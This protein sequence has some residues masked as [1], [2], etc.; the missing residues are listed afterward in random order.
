M[1]EP[2]QHDAKTEHLVPPPKRA[3]A[4]T[5]IPV[6][7]SQLGI[8]LAFIVIVAI[9]SILKPQVFLSMEN[10]TNIVK[11]T[12]VASVVG[13]GMTIV[14]LAGGI[15][16]SVGSII[17]MCG[18]VAALLLAQGIPIPIAILAALLLGTLFGFING[19]VSVRWK[20]Q[21]FLVTLGS[22]SVARGLAL[23]FSGG[24][25]VYIDNK[26]FLNI[27]GRGNIGPVPVLLIWTLVFLVI[28][29]ALI[30]RSTYG[31]RVRAV[32]GNETAARQSGVRVGRVKTIAFMLSGFFAAFAALMMAGR[33][34]SGLPSVGVGMELDAITAAVLG[35]T[36]FAGEGGSM[37]GTLF[38]ALVLG[39][40]TA[41]LTILGVDPYVQLVVKGIV[42]V[43]A[44]IL[45]SSRQ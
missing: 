42:I 41:G 26:L 17:P 36:G 32:G 24:K 38:G 29:W 19:F 6:R 23:I 11:Q 5:S 10:L 31:R 34:S 39:T 21:P 4:G 9:F 2:Q 20:I 22:M 18:V 3:G 27:M 44:V 15:D 16:L 43:L 12:A 25:T 8:I 45:A 28:S 1:K 37:I 14:M 7:L 13:F 30:N 35:G 33:L 40:I